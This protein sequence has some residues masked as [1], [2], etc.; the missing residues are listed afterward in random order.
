VKTWHGSIGV[1]FD[2]KAKSWHPT[3]YKSLQRSLGSCFSDPDNFERTSY[4]SCLLLQTT[5]HSLPGSVRWRPC[6]KISQPH[7]PCNI[8]YFLTLHIL[9]DHFPFSPIHQ[10]KFMVFKSLTIE[11]LNRLQPQEWLND[12]LVNAGIK[13]VLCL[14]PATVLLIIPRQWLFVRHLSP[15][16][17]VHAMGTFFYGLWT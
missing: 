15:D 13:C 17:S 9:P 5:S 1:E 16:H 7:L 11:D 4:V 12:E 10:N 8:L 6:G 14:P 3:L 2:T